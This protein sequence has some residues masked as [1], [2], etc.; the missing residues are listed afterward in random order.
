MLYWQSI[1]KIEKDYTV[2]VHLIDSQ[3]NIRAQRDM[4][5]RAG[6]YPTSIWDVGEI[7]RDE[8]VLDLPSGL[9]PGEYRL[10]IGLYE[11]PSLT[12]VAVQNVDGEAN[13][14]YLLFDEIIR[15]VP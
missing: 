15:V 13:S 8:Y 12:R 11:Y 14:D 10:V 1:A 3:G 9:A 2:F 7:V 6:A 5:P 4:Q